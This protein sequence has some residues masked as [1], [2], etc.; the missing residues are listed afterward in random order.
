MPGEYFPLFIDLSEKKILVVGAG[1]IAIRRV[2]TLCSFTQDILVIAPEIHG[3]IREYERS[4][5][6]CCMQKRF[7]DTDLAGR[8]LVLA[9]TDDP[10]VNV[11]I[12]EQ[13]KRQGILVNVADQ[14]EL[15]DFYFP[16][17]VRKEGA[18]IGIS[19]SGKNPGKV[20]ELRRKIERI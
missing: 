5:K 3:A 9:V 14:K 20:K 18:V 2:R 7:E 11:H 19:S 1:K 16:G 8:D 15:C 10:E 6:I 13:C 17:I 4:G 12:W